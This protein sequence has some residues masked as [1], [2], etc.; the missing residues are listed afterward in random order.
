MQDDPHTKTRFE[1][2]LPD[3]PNEQL[4]DG[5]IMVRFVAP[6][7]DETVSRV[8]TALTAWGEQL[9]GGFPAPDIEG[10]MGEIT[11]V[12]RHLPT[13]IVVTLEYVYPSQEAW[14]ALVKALDDIDRDVQRIECVEVY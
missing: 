12:S 13:E 9:Q 6:V 14:D 2:H 11:D 10:T 7:S 1:L 4:K 3:D 8:E 5:R